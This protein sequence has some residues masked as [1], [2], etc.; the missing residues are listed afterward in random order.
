MVLT[1]WIYIYIY[2]SIYPPWVLT[3]C[4]SMVYEVTTIDNIRYINYYLWNYD[5]ATV[6]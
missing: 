4:L 2:L 5:G 1:R 3:Y 6:L